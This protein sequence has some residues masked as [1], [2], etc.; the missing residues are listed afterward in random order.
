MQLGL[1]FI[2]SLWLKAPLSTRHEARN[3]QEA[4]REEMCNAKV[5]KSSYC[6]EIKKI[7]E[8]KC[9]M[10]SAL[11]LSPPRFTHSL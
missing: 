10:K 6:H 8:I 5:V 11:L 4:F 3:S 7:V 2:Y 1:V 9:N